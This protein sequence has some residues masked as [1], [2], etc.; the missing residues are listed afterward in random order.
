MRS[1]SIRA[2]IA[3]GAALTCV[4]A[5]AQTTPTRPAL[6]RP[7]VLAAPAT[8]DPG[9]RPPS[10]D[11]I[12]WRGAVGGLRQSG[13][14]GPGLGRGLDPAAV[15]K[16]KLPILLP[17]D[18]DL[19]GGARLYSF[20]DYYSI[21]ANLSGARVSLTGAA[22]TT[23]LPAG[24]K[25][26]LPAVGPEQ[27]VVQRT[28]DGQLASFVRYGVLYT[29]ELRCDAP[30]DARCRTEG[31]VRGLVAKSTVVV[32]GKAARQAAGLGA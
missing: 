11:G 12:D 21:T 4:T 27:L 28:V 17:A 30:S 24:S 8:V 9:A 2:L 18:A 19:M 25:L 29:V 14:T 3:A 7:G 26:N 31:F 10:P 20:G 22:E 32:M 6:T 23:P 1:P 16:T 13:N 5:S 15:D